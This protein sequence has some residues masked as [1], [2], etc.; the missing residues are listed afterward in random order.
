M[1]GFSNSR[2]ALTLRLLLVVLTSSCFSLATD[3]NRFGQ[4]D[5]ISEVVFRYQ[6]EHNASGQQKSAHAFCLALGEKRSDPADQLMKRFAHHRPPVRKASSCHVTSSGEVIDNHTNESALIF[7]ISSI[8]WISD[9]EVKAEGGYDEGNV[10]SSGNT[11]TVRKRNSKWEVTD[12]KMNSVSQNVLA[13]SAS[14]R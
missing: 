2:I 7:F 12:D 6:F 3:T 13:P 9:S 10:S 4:E 11:Y 8:R 1:I 14:P 5:A